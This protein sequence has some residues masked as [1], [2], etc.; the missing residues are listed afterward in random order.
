MK[1]RS[2][3]KTLVLGTLFTISL[4]AT[5]A[6]VTAPDDFEP[7]PTI[8]SGAFDIVSVE[9]NAVPTPSPSS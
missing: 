9:S 3:I 6:Q 1:K 7:L 2:F 5:F 4:S 8:S